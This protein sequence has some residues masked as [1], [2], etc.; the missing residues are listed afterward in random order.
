MKTS[1]AFIFVVTAIGCGDSGS[2]DGEGG[3]TSSSKST[4][5]SGD[6]T[7][8]T[9][10]AS[11]S[12]ANASST[13]G[14]TGCT[15]AR[16]DALGPIDEV[17]DGVVSVLSDT[18]GVATLFVDATAGGIN[19]QANNP[20]V[21]VSL[22]G[23]ARVDVTDVSADASTAW[24]IAFKR[25]ILRANNGD[26]GPVG[27]GGSFLVDKPFDMVTGAD[28]QAATLEAEVWFDQDC[29]LYTDPTG[30]IRTSFDGWYAYEDMVV[31]PAPGTWI[32][33]SGDGMHFYKIA[34]ESYYST[35][36]GGEAA[37]GGRYRFRVAELVQ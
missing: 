8:A 23:K 5:A 18:G 1:I 30:A 2:T 11:S 22:G 13:S 20:W 15:Q 16:L 4:S 7:T 6:A 9:S 14:G 37:A 34:F 12:S 26:G 17:T 21:Y 35:P 33:Q 24:D 10:T 36:Q 3:S 25:P 31:T 27:Q 32:V 29:V 19:Q 28:L